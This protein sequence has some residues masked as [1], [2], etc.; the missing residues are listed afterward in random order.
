MAALTATSCGSAQVTLLGPSGTF[1]GSVATL[2][3]AYITAISALG[4]GTSGVGIS[5]G[6]AGTLYSLF[7]W[8]YAGSFGFVAGNISTP[9]GSPYPFSHYFTLGNE[10]RMMPEPSSGMSLL[11]AGLG[12]A[13]VLGA[14]FTRRRLMS[15]GAPGRA[16]PAPQR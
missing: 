13:G 1:F 16:G 6:T 12:L 9:L 15:R 3:S 8:N 4:Y 14:R 7:F 10:V 2:V 11:G 5:D